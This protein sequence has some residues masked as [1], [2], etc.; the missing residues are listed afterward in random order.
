M[1]LRDLERLIRKVDTRHMS[2]AFGH[3]FG[4]YAAAAADIEHCLSFNTCDVVD[5]IESQRVDVV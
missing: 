1:K 5:I 4:E 3:A 2:A